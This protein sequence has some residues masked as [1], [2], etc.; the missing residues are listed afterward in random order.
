MDPV[1]LYSQ[2]RLYRVS[3]ILFAVARWFFVLVIPIIA[4]LVFFPREGRSIYPPHWW[5]SL[6][7]VWL[8][9]MNLTLLSGLFLAS[10]MKCDTCHRRPTIIWTGTPN[11]SYGVRR[12]LG[13]LSEFFV[14]AA[15]RTNR[16][17]CA[18]CAREFA[19]AA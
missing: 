7:F 11:A 10:C 14:P 15:L 12:G 1:P 5:I 4:I 9:L 16:F 8:A 18:H 13:G 19:I 3:T 6:L 17:R 2:S